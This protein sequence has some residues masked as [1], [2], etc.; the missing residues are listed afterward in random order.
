MIYYVLLYIIL[1]LW[2]SI[3]KSVYYFADKILNETYTKEQ[4]IN[5]F[6][7]LIVVNM[8]LTPLILIETVFYLIKGLFIKE[9]LKTNTGQIKANK[10]G[11]NINE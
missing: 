3:F 9:T 4:F 10:K 8:L 6:A 2:V 7:L 5:A 11:G 1:A